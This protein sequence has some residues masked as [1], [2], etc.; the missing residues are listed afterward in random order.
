MTNENPNPLIRQP[1]EVQY[2]IAAIQHSWDQQPQEWVQIDATRGEE[3]N[4]HPNDCFFCSGRGFYTV[5]GGRLKV[6]CNTYFRSI[7]DF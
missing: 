2:P 3:L 4:T 6:K 7:L 1:S 5:G